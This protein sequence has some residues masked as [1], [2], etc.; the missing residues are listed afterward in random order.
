MR[1]TRLEGCDRRLAILNAVREVFA[2]KGLEGATTRDLAKAAGVSQ[3]LLYQHFPSKESLY[4]AMAQHCMLGPDAAE[5][6][7]IIA[8]E[9]SASTLILLTHFF[10]TKKLLRTNKEKKAM[11]MIAIR[12]LLGDGD[13]MRTIH[14]QLGYKWQ[15]KFN[16][17]LAAA[18]KAG[19]AQEVMSDRELAPWLGMALGVGMML[20]L[21]PEEPIADFKLSRTELVERCVKFI[22]LGVGVK[23]EAIKKY[24]NP[25]GLALVSAG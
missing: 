15:Q 22:L 18:I 11:D 16:E 13:Y 14:K 24:Y 23:A 7:K 9:P 21:L 4:G 17:S 1:Q 5:Y 2:E 10:L 8:L 20:Y 6:E 25:K 12:S 19:E 3:A